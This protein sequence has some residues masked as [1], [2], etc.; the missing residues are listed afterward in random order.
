[1]D[2]V[3]TSL[4]PWPEGWAPGIPPRFLPVSFAAHEL[5]LGA[6]LEPGERQLWGVQEASGLRIRMASLGSGTQGTGGQG[7][8]VPGARGRASEVPYRAVSLD[9]HNSIR[10]G[11]G[12]KAILQ[13]KQNSNHLA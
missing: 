3:A 11:G 2:P 7:G 4:C 13:R 12:L 10:E 8:C 1:M 6:R 9:P 5:V